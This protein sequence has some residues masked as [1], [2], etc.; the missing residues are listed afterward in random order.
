MHLDLYQTVLAGIAAL[1]VGMF[2]NRKVGF[3]RRICIPAPV[4]GGIIFSLI[5]LGLYCLF[6][7]ETTFD[8]TIKDICMMLFFT[9]VGYQSDLSV[10]K[11]GGRFYPDVRRPRDGRGLGATPNAMANMSAVCN[12][13]RYA[14][15]PFVI[16]PIVGAMF[17]D[18]INVSIITIFLNIL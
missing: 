17:V 8:G 18:I 2:L 5:T 15:M 4:T 6:D 14:T 7:I 10:I 1:L 12:K 3:L 9:S 11:K 16:V 13:Y